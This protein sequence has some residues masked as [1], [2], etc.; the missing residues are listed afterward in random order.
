MI[1]IGSLFKAFIDR[2]DYRLY[3]QSF[4]MHYTIYSFFLEGRVGILMGLISFLV[5]FFLNMHIA[6][7]VY[8]DD[9]NIFKWPMQQHVC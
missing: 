6:I 9:Y 1:I 8:S 3:C 5:L 7:Y 2:F 4:K